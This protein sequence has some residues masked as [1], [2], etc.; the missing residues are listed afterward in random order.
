M[1]AL[2]GVVRVTVTPK[3]AWILLL[4]EGGGILIFSLYALRG[5]ASMPLWNRA[6]LIWIIAG[7]I[8]AWFYQLSGSEEVE[9]DA[10][11]VSISMN[12]LGSDSHLGV[13]T[14]PL[15]GTGVA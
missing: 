1:K 14:G 13:L 10:Q 2:S 4:V 6:L 9:F 12:I 7:A 3:P 11:K 8:V 15:P 5:W